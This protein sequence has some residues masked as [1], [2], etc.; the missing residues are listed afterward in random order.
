MPPTN[1]Q[2]D[3]KPVEIETDVER[4]DEM[5]TSQPCPELYTVFRPSQKL[6]ISLITSF[7]AMFSTMSS[8]V[9]LPAL[10]PI[11]ADLNVSLFLINLTMTS[12][13]VV[14]GVAPAFMG[15]MADQ[16]GRR[17]VY[18]LMFSLM[19]AANIGM[20]L[21]TSFPALLVLR[22]VQSAGS[23]GDLSI[24][25]DDTNVL[26]NRTQY[27]G[28]YGA[29]YGVVADITKIEERGSYVGILLLM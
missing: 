20:A 19:I 28:L 3:P 13:L 11:S 1:P 8:F 5:S 9:Y 2:R 4:V 27:T 15:D 7:A 25:A 26:T 21:Q 18:I 16:N 14:A 10:V 29:A 6:F 23:S 17:P 24:G 22:M 12:Y